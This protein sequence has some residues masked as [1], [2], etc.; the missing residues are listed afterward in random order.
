MRNRTALTTAVTSSAPEPESHPPQDDLVFGKVAWPGGPGQGARTQDVELFDGELTPPRGA[1][2]SGPPRARH[3][4]G[5]PRHVRKA[6]RPR[7]TASAAERDDRA[8]LSLPLLLSGA[9]AAGIGLTV[10][11]TSG[12]GQARPDSLS[13]TMPDLPP[14]STTP[15]AEPPTITL[16]SPRPPTTTVAPTSSPATDSPRTPA[17]TSSTSRTPPPASLTH[18]PTP[19]PTRSSA[20]AGRTPDT[21]VIQL[22]SSG[23]EVDDLQR[24]LRHLH[25][26]LGSV[27][28]IFSESVA[29]ALSRFQTARNIPEA[30]GVYGPL[31]RA[32]LYAETSHDDRDDWGGDDWTGWDD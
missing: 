18:R 22:G 9:L 28:G 31:T 4:A 15:A 5:K 23:P 17:R 2:D 19:S 3:G 6:S 12:L 7:R 26:Y 8:G 1:A 24:R 29:T 16:V 32:A 10:G 11:L 27:D 25:L 13:L 20:P 21:D 14:P 30:R